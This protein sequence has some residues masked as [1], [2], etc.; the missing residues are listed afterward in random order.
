MSLYRPFKCQV[1]VTLLPSVC[2]NWKPDRPALSGRCCF[3]L[4]AQTHGCLQSFCTAA[5]QNNYQKI[6]HSGISGALSLW[7]LRLEFVCF[8]FA[9]WDWFLQGNRVRF[10]FFP[11]SHLHLEVAAH[12]PPFQLTTVAVSNNRSP[13]GGWK[14]LLHGWVHCGDFYRSRAANGVRRACGLKGSA[15]LIVSGR[16]STARPQPDGWC[17]QD[18][19]DCEASRQMWLKH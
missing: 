2:S 18:A 11:L 14:G 13:N 4:L 7:H 17:E 15:P 12:L 9:L 5:C 8:F 19:D 16:P 3:H 6:T 1:C 10:H